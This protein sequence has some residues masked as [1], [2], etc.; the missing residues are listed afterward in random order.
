MPTEIENEID[1]FDAEFQELC[2]K[3]MN[4]DVPL[5]DPVDQANAILYFA[6]DDAKSTTGQVL[7]IDHGQAL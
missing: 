2:F 5:C 4:M 1:K 6:S 3:G 7:V